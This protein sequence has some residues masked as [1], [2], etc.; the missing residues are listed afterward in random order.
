LAQPVV[1]GAV[2]R[3]VR[4]WGAMADSLLEDHVQ[5]VFLKLFEKRLKIA[6]LAGA[7]PEQILGFLKVFTRNTVLDRL[8][9]AA[10]ARRNTIHSVALEESPQPAADQWPAVE[11]NLLIHRINTALERLPSPDLER[12][13]AIFWLFY[14]HGLS[15]QAIAD[16]P[17]VKL[18]VKGVESLLLRMIRFLRG[19]L[20]RPARETDADGVSN[21]QEGS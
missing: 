10:A 12:D 8:K 13:R 15:A 3:T 19:E 6:P 14:R 4:P 9:F 1:A 11:R 18:T 5:D 17:A 7:L 2:L 21:R 20:A 16:L